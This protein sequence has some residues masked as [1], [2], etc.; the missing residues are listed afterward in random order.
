MPSL[1][2]GFRGNLEVLRE[3]QSSLSKSTPLL[4]NSQDN[5]SIIAFFMK[6]TENLKLSMYLYG[7]VLIALALFLLYIILK[8]LK[9]N[10][11]LLLDCAIILVLIPLVSPLGWDYNLL[12]SAL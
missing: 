7:F 9:M 6:R 3:W 12:F 5:I 4:L 8:G 10:E 2:Y 11:A 1:F